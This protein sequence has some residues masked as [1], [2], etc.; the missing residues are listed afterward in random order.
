MR[1]AKIGEREITEI[2]RYFVQVDSC[3][4]LLRADR[5]QRLVLM[6]SFVLIRKSRARGAANVSC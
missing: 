5:F 2:V 6:A 1:F 3:Y 4:M